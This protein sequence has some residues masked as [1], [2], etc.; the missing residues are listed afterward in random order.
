MYR[1]GVVAR[2]AQVSVRTLRHYGEAG[3]RRTTT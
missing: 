3:L 2:F 1:I